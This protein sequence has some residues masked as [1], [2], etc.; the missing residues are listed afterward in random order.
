MFL[1]I[2]HCII[3]EVKHCVDIAQKI[4]LCAFKYDNLYFVSLRKIR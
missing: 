4:I 2:V 3:Q 1:A